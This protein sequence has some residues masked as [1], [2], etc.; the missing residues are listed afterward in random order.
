MLMS[1]SKKVRFKVGNLLLLRLMCLQIIIIISSKGHDATQQLKH[2]AE[3][4]GAEV[5]HDAEQKGR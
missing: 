3:Q 2:D 1:K 5:K 4:K